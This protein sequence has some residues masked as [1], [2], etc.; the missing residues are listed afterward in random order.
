MDL[1]TVIHNSKNKENYRIENKTF[2]YSEIKD[3]NEYITL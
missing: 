1:N 3:I 2:E